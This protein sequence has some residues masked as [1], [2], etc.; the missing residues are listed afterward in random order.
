[1]P[2]SQASFQ[3]AFQLAK[4]EFDSAFYDANAN[5]AAAKEMAAGMSILTQALLAALTE[6]ANDIAL[7]KTLL[8]PESANLPHTLHPHLGPITR[9][10]KKL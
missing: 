8:P 4:R 3:F 9:V 6:M 5:D 10:V 7:L 2:T 1:M